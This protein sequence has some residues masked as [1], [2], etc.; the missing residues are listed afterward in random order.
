MF[1]LLKA[2]TFE[3]PIS[4]TMDTATLRQRLHGHIDRA[5]HSKLLSL[6]KVAEDDSIGY[7]DDLLA[8]LKQR[9]DDYRSGKTKPIS[10][11][12]S[13][14]RLAKLLADAKGK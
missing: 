14:A 1:I 5:D 12:E 11:Q 10:A 13:K 4:P 7:D 8:E 2:I 3:S 9:V 6:L